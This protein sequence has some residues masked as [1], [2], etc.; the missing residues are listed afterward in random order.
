MR[1]GQ[2]ER[3]KGTAVRPKAVLA[4][5]NR[6]QFLIRAGVAAGAALIVLESPA[7]AD[8]P[9]AT[10]T[11]ERKQVVLALASAELI[12]A[13][14][15]PS[16]AAAVADSVAAAYGG[17]DATEQ[18]AIDAILDAI[19]GAPS[20]GTF[21]QL[22]DSQ[23]QT[24]LTTALA[25]GAAA[26]PPDTTFITD[27]QTLSSD[28]TTVIQGSFAST[29]EGDY[30]GDP[31]ETDGDFSP[32]LATS[33]PAPT[34]ISAAQQLRMT[35]FGGLLLIDAPPPAPPAVP[36]GDPNGPVIAAAVQVS[37]TLDSQGLPTDS[38]DAQIASLDGA[39]YAPIPFFSPTMAAAIAAWSS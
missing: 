2:R 38:I 29:T 5:V 37:D 36:P 16:G 34:A 35:V 27:N 25:A 28:Y 32:P 19:D 33:P 12:A 14:A 3:G 21:T 8:V 7:R 24:F 13:G 18:A 23:R 10:L 30:S 22:T 9:P 1:P 15:D 6:R 20:Q 26:Q 31:P 17:L 11:A 4:P 39:Y